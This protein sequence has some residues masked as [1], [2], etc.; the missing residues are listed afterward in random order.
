[1]T[2]NPIAPGAGETELMLGAQAR[3]PTAGHGL[4]A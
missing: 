1:M 2:V 3:A 4:L